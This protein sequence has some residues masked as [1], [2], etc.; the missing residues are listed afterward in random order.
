D[1]AREAYARCD[2]L[3]AEET[4]ARRAEV[5]I[6]LAEIADH[7]GPAE[8]ATRR[9]DQALAI[10]PLHRGAIARRVELAR[11][12]GDMVTAVTLGVRLLPLAH[13]DADRI[14]AHKQVA[15]DCL[16]AA[17]AAIRVASAIDRGDHALLERLRAVLEASGD[18]AQA[19]DVAVQL[20]ERL[21]E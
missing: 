17:A 1:A 8:E 20:A 3:L 6:C 10:A 21:D 18:H 19:V 11:R 9:L 7:L 12:A 2:S 16:Q 4:S 13:S 15:D 5:L 14:A